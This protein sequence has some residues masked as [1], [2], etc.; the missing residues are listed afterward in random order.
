M[1]YKV[2]IAGN[3]ECTFEIDNYNNNLKKIYHPEDNLD[4]KAIK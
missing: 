1:K 2:V 3:H 4:A